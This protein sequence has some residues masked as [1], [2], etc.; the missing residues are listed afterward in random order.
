MDARDIFKNWAE[1]WFPWIIGAVVLVLTWA[2]LDRHWYYFSKTP[3]TTELF[4]AVVGV[5][6]IAVGFLGTVASILL[7]LDGSRVIRNLK[8]LGFYKPLISYIIQATAVCLIT[9]ILSTTF[10]LIDDISKI[11]RSHLVELAIWNSLSA[12]SAATCIRVIYFFGVI[13]YM[14]AEQQPQTK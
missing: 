13:L 4:T 7:S 10:I 5:T 8:R 14:N 2:A 1:R 3:K 11:T 6:A 12:M 9:S